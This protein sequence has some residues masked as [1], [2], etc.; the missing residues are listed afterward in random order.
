M[1]T[2]KAVLFKRGDIVINSLIIRINIL[3]TLIH[4][5]EPVL[6]DEKCKAYIPLS[7]RKEMLN[8]IMGFKI[9][10]TNIE[11]KFKLG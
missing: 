10:I 4:L 7:Y 6:L 3:E 9:E 11:G 1:I 8:Y 2:A 5:F